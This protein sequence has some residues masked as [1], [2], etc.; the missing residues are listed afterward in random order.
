MKILVLLKRVPDTGVSLR[1]APDG[2]DIVREDLPFVTNPY[3]EYALEEAIRLKEAEVASEVVA[4]SLGDDGAS[5][6]LRNALAVGADRAIHLVHQDYWKLDPIAAAEAILEKVKAEDPQLILAGKEA[7]DDNSAAVPGLLATALGIPLL[8]YAIKLEISDGSVRV[9]RETDYGLETIEAPL[10]AVVTAEKGLNEPRLPS[11]R[12]IMAAKRKPIERMEISS[13][14]RLE[15]VGLGLP[16]AKE[17]GVKV[18]EEFPKNVEL[19]IDFLKSK[20]L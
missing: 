2:G 10:P 14:A 5:E 15:L 19:L 4:L 12:G 3:D 6:V 11:L 8:T 1:V 9:T 13:Q 17:P 7:V 18:T 20:L 16:P